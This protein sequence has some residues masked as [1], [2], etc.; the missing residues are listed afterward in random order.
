MKVFELTHLNVKMLKNVYV[1]TLRLLYHDP[2]LH[3]ENV[4]HVMTLS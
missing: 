4:K 3:L 1:I 2:I